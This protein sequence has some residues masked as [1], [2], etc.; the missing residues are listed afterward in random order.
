M[1]DKLE[2]LMKQAKETFNKNSFDN[3]QLKHIQ[4]CKNFRDKLFDLMQDFSHKNPEASASVFI[5]VLTT[6]IF[7]IAEE[8]KYPKEMLLKK[9][10]ISLEGFNYGHEKHHV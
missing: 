3:D 1:M 10:E 5:G 7:D 6:T 9:F 4:Y 8:L 2:E